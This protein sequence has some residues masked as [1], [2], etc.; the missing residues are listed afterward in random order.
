[1]LE[2]DNSWRCDSHEFLDRGALLF[3]DVE[4]CLET[5]RPRPMASTDRHYR[6]GDSS[7]S[8]TTAVPGIRINAWR[9][10]G[11]EWYYRLGP[12]ESSLPIQIPFYSVRGLRQYNRHYKALS[13]AEHWA[14]V[15]QDVHKRWGERHDGIWV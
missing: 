13:D 8:S 6:Q 9:R 11:P 5:T 14:R 15:F 10:L 1:M 7:W 2:W 4:M 3:K 12:V